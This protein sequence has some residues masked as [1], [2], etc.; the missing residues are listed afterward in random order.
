MKEE[1]D[2]WTSPTESDSGRLVMVTGRK[3]VAKFRNSGKY[4]IR[5]EITWKYPGNHAGMPDE[6]TAR[7]MEAVQDAL[8][9]TFEKDPV[10][11]MTGVYTGDDRR[12]W[13]FYITSVHIFGKKINEAL[14]PFDLLPITIYTENDPDWC[15]YDEMREASELN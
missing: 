7:I 12:D 14:A 6:P 3:D 5:A 8:T 4:K 11:V 10:A 2:W 1:L 15:E 9:E 13:V